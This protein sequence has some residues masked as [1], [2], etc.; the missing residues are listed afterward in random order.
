MSAIVQALNLFLTAIVMVGT[1]NTIHRR[2]RDPRRKSDL[3]GKLLATEFIFLVITA[4]LI[5]DKARMPLA[6]I[7]GPKPMGVPALLFGPSF[8]FLIMSPLIGLSGHAFRILL[9]DSPSHQFDE[10][11]FSPQELKHS[12]NMLMLGLLYILTVLFGWVMYVNIA[13]I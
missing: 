1:A 11:T 8:I 3:L 4:V 5:E 2:V 9:K 7:F 10:S 12:Y 13:G 6:V